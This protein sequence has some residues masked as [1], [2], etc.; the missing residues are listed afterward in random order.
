[1]PVAFEFLLN[2]RN[3]ISSEQAAENPGEKTLFTGRI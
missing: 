1:M 3:F 2:L